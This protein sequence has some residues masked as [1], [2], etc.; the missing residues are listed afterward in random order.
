MKKGGVTIFC[1]LSMMLIASVLCTLIEAARFQEMKY[2]SKLQTEL[3]AEA[4]FAKYHR[5]L[6]ETYHLLG[7]NYNEAEDGLKKVANG[8]K[9]VNKEGLNLLYAEVCTAEVVGYTRL[10]D[11]SGGAYIKAVSSYMKENMFYEKIKEIYSQYEGLKKIK[12]GA[13]MQVE[14][15]DIALQSFQALQE[16][17]L[18]QEKASKEDEKEVKEEKMES[19]PI[20]TGVNPLKEASNLKNIGILELVVQD[21]GKLSQNKIS[22]IHMVSQRELLRGENSIIEP[23]EWTD[24]ILLQ[25]YLLSHLTSFSENVKKEGLCYEI[26]YVIGGK[27]S[28]IENLKVVVTELLGIR[29][30]LNF[31]YL[32]SDIKKSE[33]A[34]LLAI[35]MVG[36]S[37]NPFLIETVK[38]GLLTAWAFGESIVDIRALLQGKRIPLLKS[39]ESWSLQLTEIGNLLDDRY[40]YKGDGGGFSYKDYL[41]ILLL[42]QSKKEAAMRSMDVQEIVIR[43]LEGKENFCMDE[44]IVNAE[45]EIGYSYKPVFFA[46]SISENKEWGNQEIWTKARYG[47]DESR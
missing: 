33:E 34:G 1:I 36:A 8:R 19:P 17:I 30:V 10:T 46:F 4:M 41:G 15:I 2:I 24:E 40:V 23:I 27:T 18:N 6:W 45:I 5:T 43:N 20:Y 42:F 21:K 3:T 9:G 44:L 7:C 29:E 11:G 12:D 26:E 37:A 38:I 47:Y 28:D 14:N 16:S 35:A 39:P 22:G 32:T 31:L 13:G 25:Q